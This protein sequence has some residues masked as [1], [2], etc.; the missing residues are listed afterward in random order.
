MKNKIVLFLLL[1]NFIISAQ[2]IRIMSYNLENYPNGQDSNFKKIVT[3]INPDILVAVEILTQQGINQFLSNSLSSEYSATSTVIRN[4]GSLPY[5]DC[6]LFYKN[7]VF[8]LIKTS[9]I[10]A[11]TR[12]ISEF[13]LVH[14]TTND[15]LIIFGAHLKAYPEDSTRRASAVT[16]LRNRTASLSNKTN[17]LICG[18]FNIFTSAETAF[19]KL[20]D[21][22]SPGYFIDLLNVS[23]SWN[24]NPQLASVCTWSTY[25]GINTRF[26]MVLISKALSDQG[27]IDYVT[28]SFKIFGNDGNHFY[29]AVN[30]GTNA[31]FLNDTSIGGALYSASDHLPVYADFNFSVSTDGVQSNQSLPTTFELMQNY[32]NPF[33]PS[34]VIGYQLPIAGYVSLKVF[35]LLGREI[36]S[37]VNKYQEAGKYNSQFS[38]S[39]SQ[40]QSGIYFYQLKVGNFAQTKKMILIK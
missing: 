38:I 26:D 40:L 29:T 23:G 27:G 19:K 4:E 8:T 17:Y 10:S 7:S 39:H 16:S 37:L 21:K 20:L 11:D 35:D 6:G 34:T 24:K 18:D 36:S 28:N 33:N 31:W 5:N 30:Y 13:K 14:K 22:T 32:P 9:E 25:G 3:Q 1:V 15:T 2:Q 12:V